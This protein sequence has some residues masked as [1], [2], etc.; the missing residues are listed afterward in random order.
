MTFV[1]GLT[2]GI[3]TGKTAVADA[4]AALGVDVTDTDRL[5]HALTERG[6]P[7]HAAILAEFGPTFFRPDGTLDRS[8]LR[9]RVFA[10]V[11]VRARLEAA[12]HPLIRD[13]ARRE[14]AGWRGPYGLLVVPLLLERGGLGGVVERVLVIDCAEDEQVRRVVARSGLAPAEV[15][16]I[17]AAQLSRSERLARADDVLDNSG[18][19]AAITP[20]VAELDRRYRA[21]AAI[22]TKNRGGTAWRG[23][24]SGRMPD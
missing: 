3:G 23:A 8:R 24:A 1:V 2:G 15:R 10:D 13:A 5:S 17:M 4:F 18:P 19:I 14:I 11:D 6:Q 9:Q 22:A 16:A 12:L 21:L 7:G 20:Q